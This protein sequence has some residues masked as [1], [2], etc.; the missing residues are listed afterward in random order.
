VG[1]VGAVEVA[2]EVVVVGEGAAVPYE[3]VGGRGGQPRGS[4]VVV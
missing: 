2:E 3:A 1:V 4:R